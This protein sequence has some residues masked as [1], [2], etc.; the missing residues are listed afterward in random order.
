MPQ[1]GRFDAAYYLATNPD[2]AAAGIDPL[3][4]WRTTGWREGRDPNAAFD[5]QFYLAGLAGSLAGL[6]PL[7]HFKTVGRAEGRHPAPPPSPELAAMFGALRRVDRPAPPATASLTAAALGGILAERLIGRTHLCV[8]VGHDAFASSVGGIQLVTAAEQLRVSGGHG[9]HLHLSPAP[10]VLRLLLDAVDIGTATVASVRRAVAGVADAR[11]VVHSPIGHDPASLTRLGV[12]FEFWL[13]DYAA[14]CAS[15]Q[16]LRNDYAFCDAPPPSSGACAICVHGAGRAAW[17]DRSL[18]AIQDAAIVA[19]SET[20][21]AVWSAGAAIDP[22]RVDVG[23]HLTLAATAHPALPRPPTAPGVAARVAFAGTP[24]FHKGYGHA[25]NLL[26]AHPELDWFATAPV[27]GATHLPARTGAADPW[28]LSR[29]LAGAAID[30]VLVLSPWP[31]TFCL[32]AHE[33][34]AAGCDVLTL[35]GGGHAAAVVAATGRGVVFADVAAVSRWLADEAAAHVGARREHPPAPLTL[36]WGG[37][38]GPDPEPLLVDG[39]IVLRPERADGAWRWVLP[40]GH[41]GTMRLRSRWFVPNWQRPEPY[42]DRRLGLDVTGLT[43]DGQPVDLVAIS[44]EGWHAAEAER[45]WTDGDAVL[46][47]GRASRVALHTGGA[48]RYPA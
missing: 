7:E 48:G 24:A 46:D 43:L 10:P 9:V 22:S 3:E 1:S 23:P 31:E 28:A 16:L 35:V 29:A 18:A 19:P 45:R 33:A 8:S 6:D 14:L 13:H 5:T 15:P 47:V 32:V 40:P 12:P 2:V 34:I 44:G 21:R 17:M 27:T 36:A 20:A 4:H 42:D 39:S 37:A 25:L 41:A 38:L 11:M 26:R 30:L